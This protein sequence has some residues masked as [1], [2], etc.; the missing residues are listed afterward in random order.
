MNFV[1]RSEESRQLDHDMKP[2]KNVSSSHL[3][4]KVQNAYSRNEVVSRGF[5]L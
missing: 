4:A 2:F 3:S 5:Q 1:R